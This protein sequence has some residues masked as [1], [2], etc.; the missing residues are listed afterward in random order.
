VGAP[1]GYALGP[2][3]LLAK[4]SETV[5]PVLIHARPLNLKMED[6]LSLNPATFLLF[7]RKSNQSSVVEM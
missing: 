3:T 6:S 1:S 4:G 7:P 2:P 5:E